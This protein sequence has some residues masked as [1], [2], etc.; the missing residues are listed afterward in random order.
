MDKYKKIWLVTFWM[1]LWVI[2]SLYA[3]WTT[4]TNLTQSVSDGDI[5]SAS[6]Y[7]S[8]NG[9]KA[10][11]KACKYSWWKL[12]CID[13]LNSWWSSSSSSS[14]GWGETTPMNKTTFMAPNNSDNLTPSQWQENVDAWNAMVQET[15]DNW[16]QINWAWSDF[17]NKIL[18]PGW[19]KEVCTMSNTTFTLPEA[20][21][22]YFNLCSWNICSVWKKLWASL[23]RTT[24]CWEWNPTCWKSKWYLTCM[25]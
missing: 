7:N 25:H 8:L 23:Q 19:W 1:L 6:Y 2:W 9:T 14:S 10:D 13:D 3:A 11:W 15:I 16:T 18:E 21:I 20:D 24:Q 4:I 17:M 22:N 5:I 12:V